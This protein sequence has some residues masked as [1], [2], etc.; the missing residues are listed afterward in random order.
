[1]A[2]CVALGEPFEDHPVPE[3]GPVV[4]V[5]PEGANGLRA[6]ILA[7]CEL[8]G[9]D[10]VRLDGRLL[11]LPGAVQLGSRV[12]MTEAVEAVSELGAVLLMLDTRARC[13]MGLEENS[14]TEQGRAIDAAERLIETTGCTTVALHHS[15]RTGGAGRGSTAWDGAVWS[16]IRVTA[17]GLMCTVECHKHKD[18]PDGCEHPFRLVPHTVSEHLMPGCAPAERETL[19]IIRRDGRPVEVDHKTGRIVRSIVRSC[20]G[21]EGLTRAEI[22]N[23]TMEQGVSRAQAYAAINDLLKRGVL[24]NVSPT[25]KE[26][27]RLS[28][29]HA[30]ARSDD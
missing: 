3:S 28:P 4:Y 29:A 11:V 1:M 19:V 13:T 12:D 2:V 20:A 5:A 21:H 8:A 22:R 6:R 30:D 9:F 27:F 16:D 25:A 24:I 18:V 15:G 7:Y 14:A 26:R 17:D 10:P 23:M